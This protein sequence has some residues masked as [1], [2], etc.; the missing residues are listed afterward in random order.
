MKTSSFTSFTFGG[1]V[2]VNKKTD[3]R[4]DGYSLSFTSFTSLSKGGVINART[5]P[6]PAGR[7]N[8]SPIRIT[9]ERSE[10]EGI[11]ALQSCDYPVHFTKMAEVNKSVSFTSAE[12]SG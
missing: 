6:R 9:S 7:F 1:L 11:I 10:R 3:R 2:E 4:Q 5:R 8:L 12:G